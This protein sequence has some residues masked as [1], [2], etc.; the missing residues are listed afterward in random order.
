MAPATKPV[1]VDL[2]SHFFPKSWPDF[3]ARFGGVP[4]PRMEITGPDTGCVMIG[5]KAFRPVTSACWDVPRRL[6]EMDRDGI[7]LQIISQTPVLFSY[8]RPIDQA[9]EVAK[10]FND[11]ALEMCAEGQGRM[12]ALCQ[13]PLQDIDA[14]CRE[15]SR[16]MKSGHR[17][18]QIGNHVGLKNLDDEGL[19][20]FLTHCAD[21]GAA[22]LV[23]PWDMMAQERMPKYMMAWT[24]GMPAETQLSI[25]AMI[26]GGA[27]DRLPRSLRIC[28]AHGGGSFAF[29]LG[30]LE[31]AW[32][33]RDV[34][35]AGSKAPP[36]TYCDRFFV[37]SAVFDDRALRLLVEVMS[38]DRVILGSDYP[39]PLGELEIGSLVRKSKHLSEAGRAKIL[40]GNALAFLGLDAAA[41]TAAA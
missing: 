38:E 28:F 24:V 19:I 27:F 9:L 17:G 6:A 40:G 10:I 26:L 31:N 25:V 32:H 4:W 8:A 30:R 20:A 33:N 15:L 16:A 3:D 5:Q 37:D 1:T 13:V 29:L 11:M 21:E 39:F 7:D 14:S 2:H 12:H 22:V 18:V 34:V 23:H 36:S 41:A 35:R